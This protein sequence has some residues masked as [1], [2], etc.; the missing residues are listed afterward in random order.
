M[1]EAEQAGE[2]GGGGTVQC[3]RRPWLV[4]QVLE[5]RTEGFGGLEL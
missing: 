4:E 2:A 1:A 3:P 5:V